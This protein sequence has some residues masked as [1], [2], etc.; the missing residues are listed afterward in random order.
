MLYLLGNHGL[1]MPPCIVEW[2][3]WRSSLT[4]ALMMMMTQRVVH[5]LDQPS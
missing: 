2:R 3:P 1:H 5:D 4:M